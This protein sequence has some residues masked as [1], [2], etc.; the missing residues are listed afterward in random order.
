MINLNDLESVYEIISVKGDINL[1]Y[2]EQIYI[3]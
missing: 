3:K 2:C 1:E